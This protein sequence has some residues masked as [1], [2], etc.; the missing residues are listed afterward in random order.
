MAQNKKAST[1]LKTGM[2]SYARSVQPS[3]GLFWGT[4]SDDPDRRDPIEVL[5]KGVRGQSSEYNTSNPGKSNPQ[6]V[7]AASIPLGCDGVELRFTLAIH[8]F[9]R[10]PWACD[11][12]AVSQAYR[13][14]VK[15]Y[16]E[17]GG[18]DT[19]ARLY[20]WNIANARFAW[21]NRFQADEMSVK[22][23]F[24]GREVVFDPMRL[25]LKQPASLDDLHAAVLADGQEEAGDAERASVDELASWISTGLAQE[26]RVLRVAWLANMAEAEEVFPSQEYLREE[27]KK[28]APSRVYAKLS[29]FHRGRTVSQASMHS[30]KI[31][32]A[33]RHIDV[34]HGSTDHVA[35]AVNP[36]GGVQETGDVL[37][38]KKAGTSFYAL[39]ADADGL[40]AAVDEANDSDAL[41]ASAHFV[42]ANLVRGGVF[43][44]KGTD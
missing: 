5:E 11:D 42:V 32:A 38:S 9:S 4:S 29:R 26:R 21:R 16:A 20:L 23:E 19:L 27:R 24:D 43:G 1:S 10:R 28:E 41:P 6:V 36:Y 15:T 2:L 18:F 37:R 25:D 13:T 44:E 40:M 8:P 17:K 3:E 34:W 30:Q 31:G 12:A 7:E 14:L 33:L 35:I 22:V 39:R